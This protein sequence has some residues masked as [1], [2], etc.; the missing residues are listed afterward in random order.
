MS[1]Q[2][3]AAQRQIAALLDQYEPDIRAA[4]LD[5]MRDLRAGVD[6]K[7]LAAALEA[8]D[9]EGGLSAL[10]LDDAALTRFERKIAEAYLAAG[11]A[12]APLAA[13]EFAPRLRFNMRSLGAEDFARLTGD[14]IT[15]ITTDQRDLARAVIE[16]GLRRGQNP[17]TTA[18][19]LVGRV[20][21]LTGRREGGIIGLTAPQ[22]ATIRDLR[23]GLAAGDPEAL[24]RYLSL[25]RRDGRSDRTVMRALREG[26]ALTA[27]ERQLLLT[28]L[29]NSYLQLRGET[30]ARTE[31][32]AA[33]SAARHEAMAQAVAA[34]PPDWR[35]VRTWV[36]ADD[37]R[38]RH[39]HAA[40]D[41]QQVEGLETP[42]VTG[43]GVRL[44]YSGDR[45]FGAGAEEIINCRCTQTHRWIYGA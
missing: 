14:K 29:S 18:L 13:P 7:A 45:K 3:K 27:A 36:A 20:S 2:A 4:F 21:K 41:G 5:A 31:T 8:G 25:K 28:R 39:S 32:M 24:R 26:R 16:D 44:R 17:K 40:M 12:A 37:G 11:E 23:A 1:R 22:E 33:I 9:I 30:V 10:R 19:D 43:A 35:I 6:L 15:R 34:A 38:T 42:F